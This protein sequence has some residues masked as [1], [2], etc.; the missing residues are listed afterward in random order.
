[1]A[2]ARG[3]SEICQSGDSLC[4]KC[5]MQKVATAPIVHLEAIGQ[6]GRPGGPFPRVL[7]NRG[8]NIECNVHPLVQRD[9]HLIHSV[10]ES[11]P[12]V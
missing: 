8:R 10:M 2:V 7:K 5:A 12:I 11:D 3:G 6:E 1:M 9:E 4:G